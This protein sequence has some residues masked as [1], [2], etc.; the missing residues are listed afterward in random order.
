MSMIPSSPDELIF[1]TL[2]TA[3]PYIA[4]FDGGK[5][6]HYMLR[7]VKTN[8]EK[9]PWSEARRRNAAYYDKKFQ[10]TSVQTPYINKDCITIY[11]QYCIRVPRR[12]ELVAH[13]RKN[14]I[15]CEVYY[16][17]PMHLQECFRDLCYREGDMPEAEK[18]AKEV[19]ALPV[20]PELTDEMKD[21]VV[22][23]ILAFLG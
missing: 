18:A 7:W 23:T 10:A 15:G 4:E 1:V 20:Y 19:I 2:D 9:G 6:A 17:V 3:T 11:N 22:E 5:T 21:F 14:S 12:D 8:G 16:P 13:L